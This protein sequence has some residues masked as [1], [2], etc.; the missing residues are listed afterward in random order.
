[1]KD[2]LKVNVLSKKICKLANQVEIAKFAKRLLGSDNI[3]TGDICLKFQ[4]E[5]LKFYQ[6]ATTYLLEKLPIDNKLFKYAQYSHYEKRNNPGASNAISVGYFS[7][8]GTDLISFI[9]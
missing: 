7:Y 1:M 3:L 4:Q 9:L 2:S 5:C 8:K 6:R